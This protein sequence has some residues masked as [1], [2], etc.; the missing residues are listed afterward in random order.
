MILAALLLT[1]GAAFADQQG[2]T[3]A[4]KVGPPKPLHADSDATGP[5]VQ[6]PSGITLEQCKAVLRQLAQSQTVT[7]GQLFALSGA[8]PK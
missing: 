4:E 1:A 5:V 3:G 7:A 2:P 8:E 6:P